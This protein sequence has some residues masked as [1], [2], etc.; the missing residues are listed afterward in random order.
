[1]WIFLRNATNV[2]QMDANYKL[3]LDNWKSSCVKVADAIVDNAVGY[4]YRKLVW[5][6]AVEANWLDVLAEFFKL[7][8][9]TVVNIFALFDFDVD[10][11]YKLSVDHPFFED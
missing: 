10:D 11:A 1:M 5:S 7:D 8:L 2:R 9:Q 4:Y 6:V 3:N